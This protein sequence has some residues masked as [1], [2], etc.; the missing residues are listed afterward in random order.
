MSTLAG[1]KILVVEDEAIIAAFV[2]DILEELGARV[3][4]PAYSV[5]QALAL[6]TAEPI[7]AALLDV[8]VRDASVIPVRDALRSRGI[9][10]V[11]ATGYGA[12]QSRE[13]TMGSP[14]ID[15]PYSP[16][17]IAR[18]LAECLGPEAG[19]GRIDDR[20]QPHQPAAQLAEAEPRPDRD[21]PLAD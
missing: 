8:N 21:G 13:I 4:G 16:E 6:A 7:D 10:I 1:A 19:T 12:S 18:A 3:V 20:A 9:P 17:R 15:K 5:P 11:F 2:V 14:V